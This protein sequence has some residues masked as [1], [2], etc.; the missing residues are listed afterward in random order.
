MKKIMLLLGICF[1]ITGVYAQRFESK[2]IDDGDSF[3]IRIKNFNKLFGEMFLPE[4]LAPLSKKKEKTE[5]RAEWRN[6]CAKRLI[7]D[8]L[9]QVLKEVG[10]TEGG[11]L[12]VTFYIDANGNV[13]T[14]QFLASSTVYVK[15]PAKILKELYNMAMKEKFDPS[16]YDFNNQR[17]YAVDGFDLMKR[18][19]SMDLTKNMTGV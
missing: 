11:G 4:K 19:V 2:P 3:E 1:C 6:N 10:E 9:K 18:A 12:W 13:L 7:T 14:V 8:K 17:T 16:C 15:L 5:K